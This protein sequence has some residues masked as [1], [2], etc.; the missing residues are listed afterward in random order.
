MRRGA[1]PLNTPDLKETYR[2][3]RSPSAETE[4]FFKID[5]SVRGGTSYLPSEARRVHTPPLPRDGPGQKRMGFFFDY[6]APSPTGAPSAGEAQVVESRKYA[7]LSGKVRTAR[8]RTIGGTHWLEA[9]LAGVDAVDE[10]GSEARQV[11]GLVD[12]DAEEVVDLSVPEHLPSSPLCPG[13]WKHRGGGR[14]VCWMHGRDVD[15]G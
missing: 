11:V 5:I 13:H 12:P 4:E 8:G 1:T 14:E 7:P 10:R 15:C 9:Q 6:T 2:V 3:K